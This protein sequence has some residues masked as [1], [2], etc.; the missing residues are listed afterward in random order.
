ADVFDALTS[1]RPYKSAWTLQA[2]SDFLRQGAGSHFDPDCLNAFFEVWEDAMV[3]RD[4]F[5]EAT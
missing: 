4:Q 3:I 5:K 1:E 2:A